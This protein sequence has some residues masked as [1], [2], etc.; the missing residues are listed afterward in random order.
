MVRETGTSKDSGVSES[1]LWIALVGVSAALFALF[2]AVSSSSDQEGLTITDSIEIE[3]SL[4]ITT[5]FADKE[6]HTPW[7]FSSVHTNLFLNGQQ[8]CSVSYANAKYEQG[9]S[10]SCEAN[11]AADVINASWMQESWRRNGRTDR[12]PYSTSGQSLKITISELEVK[13][14][15]LSS[16]LELHQAA[17]ITIPEE[18][19]RIFES[20]ARF[21]QADQ[22]EWLTAIGMI[23]LGTRVGFAPAEENFVVEPG[24]VYVSHPDTA[25]SFALISLEKFPVGRFVDSGN[26]R[27]M[28]VPTDSKT[29]ACKIQYMW[30]IEILKMQD[31]AA[32]LL[33]QADVSFD[34]THPN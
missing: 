7:R 3:I 34:C 11:E 9:I 2:L 10:Y 25:A 17:S 29:V 6:V 15:T 14:K 1:D 30:V 8:V 16:T 4:P 12:V 5:R 33:P 23:M 18:L 13:A 22:S 21:V 32:V 19:Q 28:K 31:T 27:W 20:R 24:F 26:E